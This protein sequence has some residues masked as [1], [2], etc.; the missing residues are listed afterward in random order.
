MLG[1]LLVRAFVATPEAVSDARVRERYGLL[2]GW[3]SVVIN[4]LVFAVK[5]VPGLAIG[6]VALIADASHS[7]GDVASS[8]VV[9]WGFRASAKPSDREHPFGHGRIESMASLAIAVLLLVAAV[10][11]AKASALRLLE[12]REV[13]ASL[14]LLIALTATVV[15]K[16]WL[17]TFSRSLGS[18]IGSTALE[19]D[20]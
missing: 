19:A 18:R 13:H 7:L 4:L 8:G 2:E 10:E 6:S 16:E 5:V 11:F 3:A 12:P 15:A 14:V 1:K 9:I 17:A 20:F